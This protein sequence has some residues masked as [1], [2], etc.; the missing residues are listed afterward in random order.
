MVL[1]V[2]PEPKCSSHGHVGMVNHR[3]IMADLIMDR[4]GQSEVMV[5]DSM[6]VM[7]IVLWHFYG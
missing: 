1:I 2:W 3:L 6:M 5:D 7:C 4:D